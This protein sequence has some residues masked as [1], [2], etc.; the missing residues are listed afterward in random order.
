MDAVEN[1]KR[2][3]QLEE[4]ALQAIEKELAIIHRS[5][6]PNLVRLHQVLD[7]ARNFEERCHRKKEEDHL[8]RI[9]RLHGNSALQQQLD[10]M[11]RDLEE[12]ARLIRIVSETTA[13]FSL[14]DPTTTEAIRKSLRDYHD[15]MK[16]RVHKENAYLLPLLRRTLTEEEKH[17]LGNEFDDVDHET[18]GNEARVRYES[19]LRLAAG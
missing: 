5:G 11:S 1:L 8:F 6:R 19:L 17:V 9:L 4:L 14:S 18:G 13:E 7:F 10:S 12:E 15:C 2:E 3:V 16:T